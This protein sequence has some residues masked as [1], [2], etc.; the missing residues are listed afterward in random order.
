MATLGTSSSDELKTVAEA[1]F[2][3]RE[4][5]LREGAK[6]MADYLAA[7]VAERE[8]TARLRRLRE[9]AQAAKRGSTKP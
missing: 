8:K 3:K 9:A 4:L 2:K 6:A 5:Q 7:G 1:K